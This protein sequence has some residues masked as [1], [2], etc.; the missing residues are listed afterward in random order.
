MTRPR[1]Y[2]PAG[3]RSTGASVVRSVCRGPAVRRAGGTG[4]VGTRV[5]RAGPCP[6]RC[7]AGG[8]SD[9]AALGRAAAVVRLGRDV[10][11]RADL[12][13]GRLQRADRGLPAGAGA[14][15]EDVDLLHAVLLRPTGSGLGG[16]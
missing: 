4:Q 3:S 7:V 1:Y 5:H 14:L 10:L 9:A 16:E 6:A 15:D 11:D 12:E 8:R 13:A 2:G